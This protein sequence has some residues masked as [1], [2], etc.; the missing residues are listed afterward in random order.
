MPTSYEYFRQG[1]GVDSWIAVET[2][3]NGEVTSKYMVYED[4]NKKSSIREI[5]KLTTEEIASFKSIIGVTGGGGSVTLNAGDGIDVVDEG[6]GAFTISATG[7]GRVSIKAGKGILVDEIDGGYMVSSDGS[8]GG[9]GGG[10]ATYAAGQNIS[11]SEDPKYGTL[12][13]ASFNGVSSITAG[14]G[15]EIDQTTG[16]VT[17]SAV[18]DSNA[19]S[20]ANIYYPARMITGEW[21]MVGNPHFIPPSNNILNNSNTLSA[22]V[23]SFTPY[24]CLEDVTI[25][26]IQFRGAQAAGTSTKLVVYENS[27]ANLEPTNLL[28]ET[29]GLTNAAA[30]GF[31]TAVLT[32]ALS[33]TAGNTYWFGVCHSATHTTTVYPYNGHNLPIIKGNTWDFTLYEH[34]GRNTYTNSYNSIPSSLAGLTTHTF[35]NNCP[36]IRFRKSA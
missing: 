30:F 3:I 14:R 26:A 18:S 22:G 1:N 34:T 33:L 28:V 15:L 12:I 20:T 5:E 29:A 2:D 7:D 32:R 36:F 19:A 13:N 16:D 35:A 4:P 9:S 8:G 10:G 6:G 27:P 17:I 11:F 21:Y 31:R 23:I 25:D 24:Y